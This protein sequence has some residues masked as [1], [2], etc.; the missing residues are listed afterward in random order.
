MAI[1]TQAVEVGKTANE[2]TVKEHQSLLATGRADPLGHIFKKRLLVYIVLLT[3]LL[4]WPFDVFKKNRVQWLSDSNGIEFFGDGLVVSS[5]ASPD[6]FRE[7]VTGRGLT[8]EVWLAAANTFQS[9]P[10]RIV[11]YSYG[12]ILRNFTL[13]QQGMDLVTR[14]RTTRTSLNGTRPNLVVEDVFNSSEPLHI[15]V[16]YD[17]VYQT[18]FVNG[19][20]RMRRKLPGGKFTNWDSNCHLVL[21]NEAS[22]ERPWLGKLFRIEIYNRPLERVEIVKKFESGWRI[23]SNP[24]DKAH[25]VL[26]G[27]VARYLFDEGQGNSVHNS[28]AAGTSM[29]LRIPR[30]VRSLISSYLRWPESSLG[31]TL[32][33]EDSILNIL[34]F[35]PLGFFFHG[36]LR[37]RHGL[38]WRLSAVVL[39]AGALVSLSFESLQHYSITRDSSAV[40][41]LTNTL[42]ILL[43]IMLDRWYIRHVGHYWA[44]IQTHD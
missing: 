15:V 16:T 34:G 25:T 22:C 43:G 1:I 11:S 30:Y 35:I 27:L 37:N 23:G 7:L 42:G 31:F 5:S 26:E 36:V 28:L 33:S 3:V 18:V 20:E 17:F 32:K 21:G 14:L 39:F 6:L 38:S 19:L 2:R 29:D 10:A 40:D 12:P 9:G 13:G 24:S 44:T 41:V 8:L 4:L